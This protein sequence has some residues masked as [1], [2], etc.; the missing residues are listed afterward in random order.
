MEC[1]HRLRGASA[2]ANGVVYDKTPHVGTREGGWALANIRS[3][4]RAGQEAG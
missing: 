4:G 1:F 3:Y 2:V